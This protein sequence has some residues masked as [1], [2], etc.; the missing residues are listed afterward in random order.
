MQ[1]FQLRTGWD[2]IGGTKVP[3]QAFDLL[4]FGQIAQSSEPLNIAAVVEQ[5]AV[6]ATATMYM[7]APPKWLSVLLPSVAQNNLSSIRLEYVGYIPVQS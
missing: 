4:N 5:W 2:D 1:S 6:I 7:L 3:E